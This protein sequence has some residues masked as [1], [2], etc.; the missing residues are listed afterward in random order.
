MDVARSTRNSRNGFVHGQAGQN[1]EK[2]AKFTNDL[3][4]LEDE[5]V[6]LIKELGECRNRHCSLSQGMEENIMAHGTQV[7]K[8]VKCVT[9]IT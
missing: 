2:K 1:Q 4:K 7:E 8:L 5:E 6:A 3:V 9:S